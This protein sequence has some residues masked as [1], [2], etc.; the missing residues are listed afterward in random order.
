[1][2]GAPALLAICGPTELLPPEESYAGVQATRPATHVRVRKAEIQV[3]TACSA[4]LFVDK[5]Y[6][7]QKLIVSCRAG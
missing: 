1:M 7:L 4:T 5:I 6:Y 3:S 2:E